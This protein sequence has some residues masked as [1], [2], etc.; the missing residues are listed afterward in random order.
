VATSLEIYRKLSEDVFQPKRLGFNLFGKAKDAVTVK[1]RF[2]SNK[3]EATIKNAIRDYGKD[4]PE[5]ILYQDGTN[6]CKM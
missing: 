1:G 6:Q 2:D 4:D 5:A 3:L